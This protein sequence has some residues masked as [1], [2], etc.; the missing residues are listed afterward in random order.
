MRRCGHTVGFL[1][2]LACGEAAETS[3]SRCG[4]PLCL[5][6]QR[7]GEAGFVCPSCTGPCTTPDRDSTSSG[8]RDSSDYS[9]S[10][11]SS[12]DYDTFEGGG[13]EMGG[14][15]ASGSWDEGSGSAE[16]DAAGGDDAA[17]FQDS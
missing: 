14:G 16:G 11:Y 10:T 5:R 7:Q 8:D 13:G 15:G 4:I 17:S 2:R 12:S 6:H 1:T 3:C 9:S